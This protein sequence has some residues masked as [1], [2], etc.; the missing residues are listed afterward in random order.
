MFSNCHSIFSGNVIIC[1]GNDGYL[2]CPGEVISIQNANYGRTE[3]ASICQ[4]T[5]IQ[6]TNCVEPKSIDIVKGLCQAKTSCLVSANNT[7]FGDPCRGTY[8]YLEI[9]HTCVAPMKE[10]VCE[11]RS[12]TISCSDGST[13]DVINANYG[14][15]ADGNVCPHSSIRTTSC[16][17]ENSLAKVQELC[18]GHTSCTL[19]SNNGVFGGDPCVNTYKYLEVDYICS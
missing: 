7:V 9:A 4:H 18:Q 1:E 16:S 19:A 8:K 13:I 2:N 10:I 3:G 14:R 5:S 6:T 17:A 15:T 12:R 11:G